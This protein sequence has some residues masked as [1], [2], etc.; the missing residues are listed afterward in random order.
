MNRMKDGL[1]ALGKPVFFDTK[2]HRSR[3]FAYLG[4]TLTVAATI[5]AVIFIVSVLIK[6]VSSADT[7]EADRGAAAAERTKLQNFPS[8]PSFRNTML[9]SNKQP[10]S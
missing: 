9:F 7:A 10:I 4:L 8:R 6:P 1:S 5:L 3:V 2:G